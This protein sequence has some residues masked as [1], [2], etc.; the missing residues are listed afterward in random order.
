MLTIVTGLLMLNMS[1]QPTAKPGSQQMP[2]RS[3]I[4]AGRQV[5][6]FN[7]GCSSWQ[8]VC[9]PHDWAISG[10]FEPNED[11]YAGKLPASILC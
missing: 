3:E 8:A 5:V 11:G 4:E 2:L 9:L 6:N 7:R 1:C 10:P